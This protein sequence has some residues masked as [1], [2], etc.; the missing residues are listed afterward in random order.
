MA[1]TLLLHICDDMLEWISRTH[2]GANID[3]WHSEQDAAGDG[4]GISHSI[5]MSIRPTK[6][7][8]QY[9]SALLLFDAIKA[10]KGLVRHHGA[11]HGGFQIWENGRLKG[12][13]GISVTEWPPARALDSQ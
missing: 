5:I 11:L 10:F 12:T 1:R 9:L 3:D 13:C 6:D 8:G 4:R 2:R 7:E